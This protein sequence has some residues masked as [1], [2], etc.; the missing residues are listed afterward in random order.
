MDGVTHWVSAKNVT[1]RM[2]CVSVKVL[3]AKLRKS[4]GNSGEVADIRQ[5][6][7]YTPFKRVD[8]QDEWYEVEASWGETYWIHENTVWRPVRMSKVNF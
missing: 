5:V 2:V 6:D 8:I 3:V 1:T 4:P 7:R